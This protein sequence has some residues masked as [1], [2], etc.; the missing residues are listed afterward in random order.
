MIGPGGM[1][2]GGGLFNMLMGGALGYLWSQYNQKQTPQAIPEAAM[3]ESQP[4][5]LPERRAP[6]RPSQVQTI[7]QNLDET[8]YSVRPKTDDNVFDLLENGNSIDLFGG[9]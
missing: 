9:R 3:P 4:L 8:D 6:E 5:H 2:G 7:Q 1:I